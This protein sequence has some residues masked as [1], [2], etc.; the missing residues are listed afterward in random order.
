MWKIDQKMQI[1]LRRRCK[2]KNRHCGRHKIGK[3]TVQDVFPQL[4]K[5]KE[6]EDDVSEF[7]SMKHK[8]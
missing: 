6:K 8:E 5:T 4:K 7:M 2:E 3:E 1:P